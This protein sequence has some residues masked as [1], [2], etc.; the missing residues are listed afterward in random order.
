MTNNDAVLQE[1]KTLRLEVENLKDKANETKT[2]ELKD[3]ETTIEDFLKSAKS[4]KLLQTLKKDYENIS[5]V[6]AI[7][8]FALGAIFTRSLSSK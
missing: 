6:T 8:L 2:L 5:P 7:G 1:L 3:I 4:N